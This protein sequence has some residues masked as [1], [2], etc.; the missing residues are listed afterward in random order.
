M[1][2]FNFKTAL[3]LIT[4]FYHFEAK[5]T[6]FDNYRQI[7]RPLLYQL[8]YTPATTRDYSPFY[9]IY[10]SG[11]ESGRWHRQLGAVFQSTAKVT[12]PLFFFGA[13]LQ[14]VREN[15]SWQV[16]SPPNLSLSGIVMFYYGLLV[17]K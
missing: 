7:W 1:K 3:P 17:N 5:M 13:S 11:W 6:L 10:S 4:R 12:A 2:N 8:S 14:F 9:H 16:N 15:T